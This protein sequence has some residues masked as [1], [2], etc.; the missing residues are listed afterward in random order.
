MANSEFYGDIK[1]MID[2]IVKKDKDRISLAFEQI[3]KETTK[4]ISE[5]IKVAAINN[6]YDGYNPLVYVRSGQLSNSLAPLI[7]DDSDNSGMQFSFGIKRT[8]PYGPSA[9]K[10]DTLTMRVVNKQGEERFYSYHIKNYDPLVEKII[11]NNFMEGVHPRASKKGVTDTP[12]THVNRTLNK[13]L[14]DLLKDGII[15]KIIQD[16]FAK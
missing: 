12:T 8:K 9:M 10:H 15:D 3:K 13:A 16:A 2:D 7:V 1:D 4:K 11:F 5:A 14:D 6:Y